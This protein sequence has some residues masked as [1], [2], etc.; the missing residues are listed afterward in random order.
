MLQRVRLSLAVS[1]V[2]GLALAQSAPE[3]FQK[4]KEQ[5]KAGSWHDALVTMELLDAEAAKPGNEKLQAQLEAPV[6]FYRAVCEANLD[7]VADAGADFEAFLRLQPGA[8]IDAAV[9]S[10]KAVAAFEEGRRVMAEAKPSLPRAYQD[11]QPS[12]APSA[13]VTAAWNLGPVRWL[14]GDREKAAWA[15]LKTDA[16]RAAFVDAFWLARDSGA[17]H[18]FRAAFDKRVAFS[19]AYLTQDDKTVK[20]GSLTDRGMVFILLGPPLYARRI[21]AAPPA[22]IADRNTSLS[23]PAIAPNG[24][25]V[26]HYRKSQLPAGVSFKQVNVEFSTTGGG[27]SNV[28]LDDTDLVAILNAARKVPA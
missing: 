9:Y 16:E 8:S 15:K 14:I 3:L 27:R 4:A 22:S 11:F 28:L 1:L 23:T 25:E 26:W 21:A 24:S 17:D 7:Q 13:L 12:A 19:D 6:A 5:V 18:G 10:K 2:A 20:P